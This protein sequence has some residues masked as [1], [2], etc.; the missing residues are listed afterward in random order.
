MKKTRNYSWISL[1]LAA[2][3]VP[4]AFATDNRTPHQIV[5]EMA[6]AQTAMNALLGKQNAELKTG[7]QRAAVAP[8]L[9]PLVHRASSD[10]TELATDVPQLDEQIAGSKVQLV[11]LLSVL[12]DRDASSQ[13]DA[14]VASKDPAVNLAGQAHQMMAR[15]YVTENS[16]KPQTALID[17]LEKLDRAHPDSVLLTQLTIEIAHEEISN[18]LKSRVFAI[19]T[20]EMKNSL[21]TTTKEQLDAQKD[22][23]A[24]DALVLN[25]PLTLAGKTSDGK[26][27]S[28]ADLKGKVILVDFWATWCGPCKAELPRVKKVYDQYHLKGL[29]VVG[30]SNDYDAESL[31]GFVANA[32][33][34]W[35]QLFDAAAA[36]E[37]KWNA[38]TVAQKIDG[39]P[40]MYLIDKKGD[41]R[42]VNARQNMEEL[43]PQ[44]LA[45]QN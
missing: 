28:T 2:V 10:L 40:V 1:Y 33:L 27:F 25:K 35:P 44:L 45:E 14:M 21:A 42:T 23:A 36:A 17:D 8:K 12:G 11:A 22:A 31:K 39:I 30:V 3:M 32:D 37:H 24:Q 16:A 6:A 19:V 34:P 5:V 29:E 13:I 18:N 41:L 9:M 20:D 4:S 43:I 15:F 38:I 7:A 26:D